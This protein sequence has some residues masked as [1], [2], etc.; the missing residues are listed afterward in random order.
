MFNPLC[1]TYLDSNYALRD[2]I[3]QE[4]GVTTFENACL[5]GS[6]EAVHLLTETVNVPD[7]NKRLYPIHW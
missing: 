6:I 7:R 1:S 2:A 4:D 3:R 5:S